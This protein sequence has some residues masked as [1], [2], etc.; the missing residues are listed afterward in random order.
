MRGVGFAHAS[1][2]NGDVNEG[3]VNVLGH[4]LLITADVEVGPVFEPFPHLFAVFL[5]SVLDIDFFL[6]VTGQ[7][8]VN[9]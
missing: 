9:L 6:L 8:V 1:V 3:T 5:Q 4:V 2:L 7:A